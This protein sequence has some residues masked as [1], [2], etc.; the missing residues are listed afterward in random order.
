MPSD[1]KGIQRDVLEGFVLKTHKDYLLHPGLVKD[2]I[3]GFH[4]ELNAKIDKLMAYIGGEL[5]AVVAREALTLLGSSEE[6]R[7]FV[8]NG[9]VRQIV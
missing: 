3:T 5:E 4:A 8:K 9:G 2:S 6:L 1:A 7:E